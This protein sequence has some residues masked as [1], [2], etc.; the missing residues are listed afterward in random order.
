MTS[1]LP[2]QIA[3]ILPAGPRVAAESHIARTVCRRAERSC[4]AL[5]DEPRVEVVVRYL[6]RLSDYLFVFGR[7]VAFKSGVED[8]FWYQ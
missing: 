3:F 5:M 2:E 6:N 7:Y 1:E 8:D 4:V